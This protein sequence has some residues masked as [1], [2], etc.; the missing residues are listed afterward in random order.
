MVY[1]L[2]GIKLRRDAA[3]QS[4]QGTLVNLLDEAQRR[5]RFFDNLKE[6]LLMWESFSGQQYHSCFR[7]GR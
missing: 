4:E 6:K 2:S 3:Q 1:K 7:K 5:I